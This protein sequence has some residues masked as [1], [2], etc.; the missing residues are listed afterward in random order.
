MIKKILVGLGGTPFSDVAISRSIELAKIHNAHIT[1][2]SVL[3]LKKIRN[4]GPVPLGAGYYAEKLKEKRFTFSKE[5]IENAIQC[6]KDRCHKS[7]VSYSLQYEKSNAFDILIK[8]SK[9]HD[10][11]ILGRRSVLEYTINDDPKDTILSILRE[12]GYPIIANAEHYGKINKVLIAYSGSVDS[13]KSLKRFFQLNI[14]QECKFKIVF[15]G[16]KNEDALAMMSDAANFCNSYGIEVESEIIDKNPVTGIIECAKSWDADMLVM[17]KSS[18]NVILRKIFG[19]TLI[20]IFK[21]TNI[22]IFLSQ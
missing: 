6:F 15:F 19:D 16:E 2:V 12:G 21:K 5:T 14:Y 11:I 17:G 1:G 4:V 22:P 7:E 8:E 3:D 20:D 10:I 13:A 18:R 9:H